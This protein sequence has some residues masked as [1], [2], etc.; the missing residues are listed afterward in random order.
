[1]VKQWRIWV[2]IL[3][4]VNLISKEECHDK[5]FKSTL[6]LKQLWKNQ[7]GLTDIITADSLKSEQQSI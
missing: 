5:E 1:M 7:A 3:S 6:S 2:L 4:L